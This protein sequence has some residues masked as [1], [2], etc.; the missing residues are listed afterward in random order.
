MRTYYRRHDTIAGFSL[1]A[2]LV[3]LALVIQALVALVHLLAVIAIVACML[4]VV[5][6]AVSVLAGRSSL[7]AGWGAGGSP[8]PYSA[9]NAV[10]KRSPLP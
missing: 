3:G 7:S 1:A 2:M 8:R 9:Q 4:Y 6:R 5:V 10:V